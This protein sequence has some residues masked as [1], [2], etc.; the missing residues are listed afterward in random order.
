MG[1]RVAQGVGRSRGAAPRAGGAIGRAEM[2]VRALL[3]YALEV[4][5]QTVGERFYQDFGLVSESRRDDAVHLRPAPLACETVLLYAGPRKRLHHIAFGAPGAAFEATAGAL[6][7]APGHTPAGG[8]PPPPPPPRRSGSTRP[9]TSRAW[10]CADIPSGR[11]R[12]RAGWAMSCFSPRTS[13]GRS[14]STRAC[15]ASD[16]PIEPD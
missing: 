14:T 12:G 1:R 3:H 6:R 5:D 16:S 13:T 15:S 9:A 7:R 11:R 8:P 4:P 10:P 2:A